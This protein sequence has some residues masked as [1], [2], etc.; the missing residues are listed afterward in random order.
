MHSG[1]K[2]VLVDLQQKVVMRRHQTE[3]EADPSQT[4][5]RLGEA[6]AEVGAVIVVSEHRDSPR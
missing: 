1:L 2:R 5:D 6:I 3:R 4:L